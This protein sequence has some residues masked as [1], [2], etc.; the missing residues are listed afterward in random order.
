M[1]AWLDK[2]VWGDTCQSSFKNGTV[3]GALHAFHPGSRLHILSCWAPSIWGFWVDE[4]MSRARHDF[5]CSTM[6]FF[7]TSWNLMMM[8]IRRK[9]LLSILIFVFLFFIALWSLTRINRR[10]YLDQDEQ[11]LTRF[12]AE[13][14]LQEDSSVI[15]SYFTELNARHEKTL[16]L[17]GLYL[18]LIKHIFG[19]FRLSY[20]SHQVFVVS[21]FHIAEVLLQ[22]AQ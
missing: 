8:L 15:E 5:A 3:S 19:A 17:L 21:T 18:S 10:W 6:G 20:S 13:K 22:L 9:G 4:W 14:S 7:H 11:T 16:K 2:T 1:L 12:L